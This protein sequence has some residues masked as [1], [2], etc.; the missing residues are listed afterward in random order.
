MFAAISCTV[1]LLGMFYL[2]QKRSYTAA[3]VI[4]LHDASY[5]DELN[6]LYS[7]ANMAEVMT[8]LGLSFEEYSMD[9]LC[10]AVR[11][12]RIEEDEERYRFKV[13]CTLGSR[14]SEELTGDI[15]SE[16]IDTVLQNYDE[17][18]I[19]RTGS[20]GNQNIRLAS[21]VRVSSNLNAA[22]YIIMCIVFAFL[23]GACA[24]VCWDF[25]KA[26]NEQ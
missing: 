2:S 23:M 4:E 9:E 7:S 8:K 18:L 24:A 20:M 15:L 12:E 26:D 14:Y 3:A 16:L 19:E 6:Y 10:S 21:T 22:V 5:E 11:Y 17:K 25:W 1:L 13:Q